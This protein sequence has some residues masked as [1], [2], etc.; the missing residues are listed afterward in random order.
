[1]TQ[2]KTI[3]VQQDRD[4]A[5]VCFRLMSPECGREQEDALGEDLRRLLESIQTTKVIFDLGGVVSCSSGALGALIETQKGLAERSGQLS[6]CRLDDHL[7]EKMRTLN[8]EDTVF[9]IYESQSEAIAAFQ[10]SDL[11]NPNF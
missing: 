4:V 7:R 3:A 9:S 5:I 11:Q 6:L 1:M 10:R 2:F 8:L